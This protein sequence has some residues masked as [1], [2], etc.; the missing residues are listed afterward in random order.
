[1]MMKNLKLFALCGALTASCNVTAAGS[2]LATE[3]KPY[4]ADDDLARRAAPLL[5]LGDPFLQTGNLAPGFT[6]PGGAIWQPRLWLYGSARSSVQAW[7]DT[8]GADQSEWANR[9]DL[10]ANL[11]LS[12]TERVL[13][14]VQPLHRDGQFTG[15]DFENDE[16]MEAYNDRVRTLFFEGDF[17]ELF[18]WLDSDDSSSNDLGFSI[19]RQPLFFQDGMLINDQLDAIG[20]SRNNLRFDNVA[21]L[22]NLHISTVFAWNEVHRADNIEDE[23]SKLFGLF[24]QWDTQSSTINTDLAFVQ[25]RDELN[26]DLWVFGVDAIQRIGLF[27]TTFR[28]N[29]SHAP[30]QITT[31]ADNGVLLFTEFSWS[32]AHTDNAAYI[33]GFLGIDQF[34]SAARDPLAGGPLGRTG[35]LFAARGVGRAPAALSNQADQAFGV[36]AGYQMFFAGARRQLVV[37]IGGRDSDTEGYGMGAAAR[38]QQALGNRFVIVL[39]AFAASQSEASDNYGVAAE[40]LVKF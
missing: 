13:I 29:V 11:Q 5:E 8:T 15:Q 12:G 22:V 19:G 2:A 18:P 37:E 30:D 21:W 23:N 4:L 28:V 36:A 9:L 7:R 39:D 38:L 6:L 31:Q 32:P 40:L 35:I 17:A 14:G 27:N 24:A 34:R 3:P 20:I 25:G 1:M 10:F 33:N 26:D 16:S